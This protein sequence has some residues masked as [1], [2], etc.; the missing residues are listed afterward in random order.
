MPVIN[1]PHCWF[2]DLAVFLDVI[3]NPG[4]IYQ[5]FVDIFGFFLGFCCSS[6]LI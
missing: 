4:V 6:S 3:L 5:Y 2:A 1:T